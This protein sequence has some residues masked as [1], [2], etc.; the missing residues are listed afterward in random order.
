MSWDHEKTRYAVAMAL[1]VVFFV[2]IGFF[3]YSTE[4]GVDGSQ[5]LTYWLSWPI[6]FGVIWWVALGAVVGAALNFLHS[7]P[8][9][10]ARQRGAE[11]PS[12]A[13]AVEGYGEMSDEERRGRLAAIVG[14]KSSSGR[15]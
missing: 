15:T 10:E 8:P 6:R 12:E 7:R 11:R 14:S 4:A 3:A 9:E 2:L 1:G 13:E 5:P